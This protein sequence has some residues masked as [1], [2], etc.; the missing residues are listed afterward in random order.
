MNKELDK[1]W[2][3]HTLAKEDPKNIKINQVT[4]PLSFDQ[5]YL[6]EIYRFHREIK[7]KIAFQY[8]ICG[9]FA[10]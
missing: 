10:P 2:L 5:H 7:I 3:S 8:I 6:L 1:V 4:H 9:S